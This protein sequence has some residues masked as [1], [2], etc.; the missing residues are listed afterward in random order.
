MTR[1]KAQYNS[2]NMVSNGLD[3]YD[4]YYDNDDGDDSTDYDIFLFSAR[5]RMREHRRGFRG[6]GWGL[7]WGHGPGWGRKLAYG[8][9]L[10]TCM[11]TRRERKK[12]KRILPCNLLISNT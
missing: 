11:E 9:C 5:A 8:G 3:R 2:G 10:S 7:G 4:D 6:H 12:K 1:Y